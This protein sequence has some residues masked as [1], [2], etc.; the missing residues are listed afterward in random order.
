MTEDLFYIL[1]IIIR[2]NFRAHG[3]KSVVVYLHKFKRKMESIFT[4]GVILY[5]KNTLVILHYAHYVLWWNVPLLVSI[6][7]KLH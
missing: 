2:F 5:H 6:P 1:Y 7:H 4:A 3:F